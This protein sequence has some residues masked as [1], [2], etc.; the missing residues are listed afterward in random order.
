MGN[1]SSYKFIVNPAAGK[2]DPEKII[3]KINRIFKNDGPYFDIYITRGPGD[4][5][6]A[7]KQ[8]AVNGTEVVVAVGGDGTVNEVVNGLVDSESL[9]AVIPT[10]TGNDFAQTVNMPSD[11]EEACRI[12]L[13]GGVRAVDLGRVQGRSFI[14]LVGVGFD[15]AVA[16]LTNQRPKFLPGAWMYL[17]SVIRTLMSYS[18]ADMKI[19]LDQQTF[20]CTPLLVAVGIGQT[21]GGGIRI[22]PGAVQDDGLFDICVIDSISKGQA[23]YYLK[24]LLAGEHTNLEK[25]FFKRASYVKLQMERALP[26]HVEGE[27][28]FSSEIEF[29]IKTRALEVVTGT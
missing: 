16:D 27:V 10:G 5:V 22:V 2:R 19:T 29:T 4:A 11:V 28:L 9:L 14:N 26:F 17:I 7:A 21:Y 1:Y 23:I 3:N 8:A 24:K 25:T 12:I 18:P 13:G 6:R 20:S 15:G